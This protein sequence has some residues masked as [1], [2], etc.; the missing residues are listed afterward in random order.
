MKSFKTMAHIHSLDGKMDEV[1]VLD[2]KMSGN[3][4]TYIVDYN[5]IKCT[6]V[7]NCFTCTYFA[8][9]IYGRLQL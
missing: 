7:F 9:D 5:G 1:T 4:K 2:E 8:D 3:Q 6:A